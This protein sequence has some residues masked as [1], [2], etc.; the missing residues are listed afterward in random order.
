VTLTVGPKRAAQFSLAQHELRRTRQPD[1]GP[2]ST[3]IESV[4][5]SPGTTVG[6]PFAAQLGLRV[7]F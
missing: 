3:E 6:I 2:R 4:A 7:I 5:A 1:A